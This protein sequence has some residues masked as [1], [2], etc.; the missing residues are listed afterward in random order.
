MGGEKLCEI[1][2]GE[3]EM[4]DIT[5]CRYNGDESSIMHQPAANQGFNRFDHTGLRG[6]PEALIELLKAA[7][8]HSKELS[9]KKKIKY[10]QKILVVKGDIDGI[11]SRI[12]TYDDLITKVKNMI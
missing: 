5:K 3:E 6:N 7:K 10:S 8:K 9:E 2:N 12:Y 4:F 11:E 1:Y